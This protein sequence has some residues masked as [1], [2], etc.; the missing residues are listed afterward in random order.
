M[1]VSS[2]SHSNFPVLI[3]DFQDACYFKKILTS[4]IIEIIQDCLES[5]DR[6]IVCEWSSF[7][8]PLPKFTDLTNADVLIPH[9]ETPYRHPET[10][11][12]LIEI[13]RY[14]K[15]KTGRAIIEA[16]QYGVSFGL[17]SDVISYAM[18]IS[19]KKVV[20]E[21]AGSSGIHAAFI[22]L[23]GATRVY[24][25]D[26][27]AG[28]IQAFHRIRSCFP[29]NIASKLEAIEG[30]CL[31]IG[32]LKPEILGKIDVIFCQNLIHF[33]NE[34][35]QTQFFETLKSLLKPDGRVILSV[36]SKYAEKGQSKAFT[37]NPT[38]TSFTEYT[39]FLTDFAKGTLPISQLFCEI[40][41]CSDQT[42][43]NPSITTYLYIR[44]P[45]GNWIPDSKAYG[46][47]PA[48]I[49]KKAKEAIA[50]AKPTIIG[51]SHGSVRIVQNN[52]RRYGERTL[53]DLIKQHGFFVESTYVI[54]AKG[55]RV[56]YEDRYR[57]GKF[58]GAVFF[59]PRR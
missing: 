43:G 40:I 45:G 39:C 15:A 24:M 19:A 22:A 16:P 37:D 51:I 17:Q 21:I 2:L 7:T 54:S 41:P 3:K 42:V 23:G 32:N 20:L 26:I 33:F 4:K 56:N 14:Y 47:L 36:N 9:L 52:L 59:Q 25:N 27:T 8:N 57:Q 29:P 48:G 49:R 55:H 18:K 1:L 28:E 34:K 13:A 38:C 12:N 44:Q 11:K 6:Q 53:S 50:T 46:T 10:V 35:Q 58:V 31:N 5:A 30:D